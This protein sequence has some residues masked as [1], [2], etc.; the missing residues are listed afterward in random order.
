V[1]ATVSLSAKY[2]VRDHLKPEG[3]TGISAKQIEAHWQLYEGYVKNTNELLAFL[4]N[5]NW[6]TVAQRFKDS[7]G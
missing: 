2:P 7:A 1:I 4:E 6:E 5:V 3:L